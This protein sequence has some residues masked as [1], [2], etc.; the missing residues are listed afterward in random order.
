MKLITNKNILITAI[1][2]VV[3][4]TILFFNAYVFKS[5]VVLIGVFQEMLTMP[6]LVL[7]FVVL[8]LAVKKMIEIKTLYNLQL[9][10]AS[11]LI[12]VSTVVTL[13]SFFI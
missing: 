1:I 10:S 9:L 11:I 13:G 7:Q 6:M 2:V 12:F 3:Y 4:F 8:F 5:D